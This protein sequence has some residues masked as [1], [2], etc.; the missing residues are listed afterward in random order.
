MD[1]TVKETT[2][3]FEVPANTED[4]DFQCYCETAVKTMRTHPYLQQVN[5]EIDLIDNLGGF[6]V[7]IQVRR[8]HE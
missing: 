5:A 2:D 8:K 3:Y 7:L 1:Q 6:D 4:F